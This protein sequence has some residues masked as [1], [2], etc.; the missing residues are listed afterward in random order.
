MLKQKIKKLQEWEDDLVRRE[1][2]FKEKMR[3]KA[4]S[5]ERDIR[6]SIM[7]QLRRGGHELRLAS[8]NRMH[9]LSV[10]QALLY[11]PVTRNVLVFVGGSAGVPAGSHSPA[12]GERGLEG[13]AHREPKEGLR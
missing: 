6:K 1:D 2:L 10:L 8:E 13:S 12:K 9:A 11:A 4:H 3:V 5:L 7:E